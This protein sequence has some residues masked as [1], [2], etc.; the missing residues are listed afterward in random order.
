MRA[1]YPHYVKYQ[2]S[3]ELW[4]PQALGGSML[5]FL[6]AVGQLICALGLLYGLI[7]T[8][9]NSNHAGSVE[10]RY[11]PTIGHDWCRDT[12]DTP[13]SRSLLFRNSP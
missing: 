10:R 2:L 11:D 4:Q 1:G 6:F 3:G 12:P 13:V 9:A 5:D 8:L 7:L